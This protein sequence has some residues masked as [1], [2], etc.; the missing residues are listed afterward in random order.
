MNLVNY[1]QTSGHNPPLKDNNM[2]KKEC[3]EY[4][5]NNGYSIAEDNRADYNLS[6]NDEREKFISDMCETESEHF[7]QFTPFEFFAHD[8]NECNNQDELWQ[9]YENGVYKGIC[10]LVREEY[11]LIMNNH[12]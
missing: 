1:H 3:Y 2:N 6:D 12:E 8:V 5:Y 10:A 7:R 9:A 11:N 4:G